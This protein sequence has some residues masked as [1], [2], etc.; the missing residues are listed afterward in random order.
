MSYLYVDLCYYKSTAATFHLYLTA[1]FSAII[2]N[3][4]SF[5]F[6]LLF[7]ILYIHI[8][9]TLCIQVHFPLSLYR[10]SYPLSCI[11]MLAGLFLSTQYH[12]HTFILAFRFCAHSLFLSR[13][14][15]PHQ[16]QVYICTYNC[17][18]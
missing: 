10:L 3:I 8:F 16:T 12:I 1:N 13:L 4:I 11:L 9:T 15:I 17:M 6:F 14:F 2:P 7:F 18:T 5:F